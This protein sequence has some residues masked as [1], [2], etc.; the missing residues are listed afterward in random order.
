MLEDTNGDGVFDKATL[1][2]DKLT[3]PQGALWVYD[4]LYVMSP[5]SLWRFADEDGDGRA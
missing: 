3:F 2:A 1:F 4:S 5:P